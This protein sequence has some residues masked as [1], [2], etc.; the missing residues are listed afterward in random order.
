[1]SARSEI[2]ET[3]KAM[4]ASGVHE[5]QGRVYRSRIIPTDPRHWPC[6]LVVVNEERVE[7]KGGIP[8]RR[9]Q[10]R[11]AKLTVFAVDSVQREDLEDRLESFSDRIEA[12]I[13]ADWHLMNGGQPKV[14]D[15]RM[16]STVATITPLGSQAVGVL[17]K[18]FLAEYHTTESNPG[19]A[20]A[21]R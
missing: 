7:T 10:A 18:D 12:V 3:V 21:A 20:L 16:T 1:M 9:V 19:Q 5:V 2:A 13:A 4:L 14:S 15:L 6:L 11:S 8:G 17:R